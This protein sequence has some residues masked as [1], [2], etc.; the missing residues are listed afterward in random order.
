MK[1]VAFLFLL[2]CCHC[3]KVRNI[4]DVKVDADIVPY[5]KLFEDTYN[6]KSFNDIHIVDKLE[7]RWTVGTCYPYE[8][9]VEILRS[10]WE[11]SSELEKTSLLFHELGHCVMDWDHDDSK[12]DSGCPTS[13]MA[14]NIPEQD[15]LE[16][17]FKKKVYEQE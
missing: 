5:V 11:Y 16:K 1:Y 12:D 4:E 9:K 6:V 13:F 2:T 15:C 14:T 7:G 8:S 10:F 3:S 17:I